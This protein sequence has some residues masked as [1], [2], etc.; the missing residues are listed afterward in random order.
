M[1]QAKNT[2]IASLKSEVANLTSQLMRA[3]NAAEIAMNE[4]L[5]VEIGLPSEQVV[6]VD[7]QGKL[8]YDEEIWVEVFDEC[9]DEAKK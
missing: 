1:I 7:E 6:R 5:I 3:Q 2:V 9:V 4:A 8:Y